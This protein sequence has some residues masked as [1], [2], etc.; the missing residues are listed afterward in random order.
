MLGLLLAL[1]LASVAPAADWLAIQGTEEGRKDQLVSVGG[2][3]QVGL[4]AGV[5]GEPVTGLSEALASYEGAWPTFQPEPVPSFLIRRARPILRGALPGTRQR[6]TW[7]LA[8]EAGQNAATRASPVVLADASVTF[9]AHPAFSV[10]LGRFKLPT[11]EE[12]LQAHPITGEVVVFSETSRATLL[13]N[14]VV[15]G[16]YVGGASAFRDVGA[17]AF[18]RLEAGRHEWV[19]AIAVTNGE[20]EVVDAHVDLTGRIRYAYRLDDGPRT[21][22]FR[23]ELAAWGFYQRGDRPSADGLVPRVRAGLGVGAELGRWRVLAEVV[24]ADGWIDLGANPPFEGAPVVIDADGTA[25][26]A[27]VLA[28][29][30][31]GK[32]AVK[33]RW[34]GLWRAPRDPAARRVLHSGLVGVRWQPTPK[35]RVDLDY[36]ARVLQAPDASPD[37]QRI[38]AALGDRLFLEATVLF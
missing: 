28:R 25:V 23:K 13:E 36:E 16:R 26:G 17:L 8:V 27:T 11:S 19:G 24:H 2:F 38:A 33:V 10:R 21:A 30:T 7:F 18:G 4:E 9:T 20:P 5:R 22:P 15:A 34:A 14:R 35:A 3:L 29:A 6:V 1:G 37:A 32:F 31:V 12:A